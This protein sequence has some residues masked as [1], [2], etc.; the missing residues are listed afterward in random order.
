MNL[1]PGRPADP[2]ELPDEAGEAAPEMVSLE[3]Y[4][5]ARPE[6]VTLVSTPRRQRG[7]RLRTAGQRIGL[8]HMDIAAQHYGHIRGDLIRIALIAAIM[9]GAIIA[10]SFVLR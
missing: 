1:A 3:E 4:R 10:L 2:E 6:P 7:T 9:F 8:A 5:V